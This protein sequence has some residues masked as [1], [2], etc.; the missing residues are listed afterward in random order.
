MLSVVLLQPVVLVSNVRMW[1]AVFWARQ[2]QCCDCMRLGA[3]SIV[4][5][6]L[7]LL[8]R[9]TNMASFYYKKS[10]SS[11]HLRE[12]GTQHHAQ[13]VANQG[14]MGFQGW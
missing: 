11:D 14:Y 5:L 3:S 2:Y 8:C 12:L 9:T 7:V 13:H 6:V 10:T 4:L 1:V